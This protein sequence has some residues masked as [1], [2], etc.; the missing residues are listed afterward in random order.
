MVKSYDYVRCGGHHPRL[1][2]RNCKEE[3]ASEPEQDMDTNAMILK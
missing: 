3:Q 1:I 2:N